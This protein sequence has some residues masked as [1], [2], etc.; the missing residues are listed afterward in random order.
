MIRRS[1]R[2]Y[3]C[4]TLF[5]I[6]LFLKMNLLSCIF[7]QEGSPVDKI[8]IESGVH[9]IYCEADYLEYVRGKGIVEGHGNVEVEYTE[10]GIR[11]DYV[12]V[13]FKN[14]EIR[15]NGNVS[16]IS[17]NVEI[18]GDSIAY[19]LKTKRGE[20]YNASTYFPPVHYRGKN[21][22]KISDEEFRI[23]N[24]LFTTCELQ[25]PHYR[26][27]A[28]KINIY[29]GETIIAQNVAVF[30][31]PVPVFYL[32]IL[33]FP[34]RE[35]RQSWL[36]PSV[37]Y[38]Q[39]EGWYAKVGYNYSTSPS[40]YG[41]V[42]LKY[43]EKKGLGVGTEYEA[44]GK[45]WNGTSSLYYVRQG[46]LDRYKINL[47]AQ[48]TLPATDSHFSGTDGSKFFLYLYFLSDK[49]FDREYG[50]YFGPPANWVNRKFTAYASYG[51]PLSGPV[52]LKF[53]IKAEESKEG[54][55]YSAPRLK[56]YTY[57]LEMG[58]FPVH[59]GWSSSV[60]NYLA[61]LGNSENYFLFHNRVDFIPKSLGVIPGLTIGS[62]FCLQGVYYNQNKVDGE[63]GLV[64]GYKFVAGPRIQ[65]H[66]DLL[67][68][69]SYNLDSEIP[70]DTYTS[71]SVPEQYIRTYFSYTGNKVE[72]SITGNYDLKSIG[73]ISER[74]EKV[75][76][77][78][79][80]NPAG[81]LRFYSTTK[82]NVH[83]N[84]I[85]NVSYVNWIVGSAGVKFGG[86]YFGQTTNIN[87]SPLFDLTAE[88]DTTFKKYRFI[89]SAS[90]DMVEKKFRDRD[91]IIT[92]DLHCWEASLI[93]RELR[94]EIWFQVGIK[95]FPGLSVR[96]HPSIF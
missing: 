31:G 70:E 14:E 90:Y 68:D 28:S 36:I 93:Y 82:Y 65:P 88:I 58:S 81:K 91:Y 22:E 29:L 95:A 41:S 53:D 52:N 15:A 72:A 25:K 42:F 56:L 78:L 87:T 9:P 17:K 74:F 47:K 48:N 16:F 55:F 69:I 11:A 85:Q 26:L 96:F 38:S 79:S 62:K 39:S 34:L 30:V 24:G 60:G 50:P 83:P 76:L 71:T 18:V 20:V 23:K 5:F 59:T 63:R 40:A 19:N 6:F 1:G 75:R 27:Q 66:R 57:P 7:A 12:R 54:S 13:D 86:Q 4:L 10:V 2:A 89:F 21:I 67:F 32:P 35:G 43:M 94:Q 92:R 77:D 8:E 49:D 73:D 44:T 51:R 64:P 3:P 46:D 61:Y 84:T 45:K 80:V 33:A 37:G